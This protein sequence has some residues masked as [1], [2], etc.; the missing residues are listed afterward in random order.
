MSE[1]AFERLLRITAKALSLEIPGGGDHRA[2]QQ[3]LAGVRLK[4]FGLAPQRGQVL[5]T[6]LGGADNK[7]RRAGQFGLREYQLLM[8]LKGV[9]NAGNRRTGIVI[10]PCRKIAAER[11]A[12]QAIETTRQQ[13]SRTL[14]GFIGLKTIAR[15]AP[16]Q[17]IVNCRKIADAAGKRTDMVKAG[18][19]GMTAGARQAAKSGLKAKDPA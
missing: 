6:A 13:I 17:R 11:G 1:Q 15:I 16:L 18:D 14:A 4:T 3:P 2:G 10:A 9:G 12:A 19:K 8:R 7:R 5:V